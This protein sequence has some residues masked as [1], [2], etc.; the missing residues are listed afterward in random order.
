M[1][2]SVWTNETILRFSRYTLPCLHQYNNKFI[3]KFR[4][5]RYYWFLHVTKPP[6]EIFEYLI[7]CNRHNPI[8]F[9]FALTIYQVHHIPDNQD[10]KDSKIYFHTKEYDWLGWDNDHMRQH[11]NKH[12]TPKRLMITGHM[13]NSNSRINW[14]LQVIP[15]CTKIITYQQSGFY[16]SRVFSTS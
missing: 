13:I 4:R 16:F 2:N 14:R 12:L 5:G 8:W 11:T 3:F 9:M 6:K 1:V 10:L 7:I 15:I